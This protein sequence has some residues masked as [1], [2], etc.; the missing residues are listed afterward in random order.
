MPR[1]EGGQYM[2]KNAGPGG[3]YITLH[4]LDDVLRGA[5]RTGATNQKWIVNDLGNQTFYIT[6]R[7]FD[8]E[9][10][11]Y[12]RPARGN[13]VTAASDRQ[14]WQITE[15]NPGIYRISTA[16]LAWSL[17]SDGVKL[18]PFDTAD[19]RQSFKFESVA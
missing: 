12:A 9:P 17:E 8:K 14:A 16:N 10:G 11:A 4:T 5:L 7:G 6:N 19:D 2:I 3:Q 1:I 15:L 18:A 13:A